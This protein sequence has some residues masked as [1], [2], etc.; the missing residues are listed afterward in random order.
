[1]TPGG[2]PP[3]PKAWPQGQRG[4]PGLM[5]RETDAAAACLNKNHHLKTALLGGT[6]LVPSGAP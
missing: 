6:A 1:M 2:G 3:K 5:Q 4:K